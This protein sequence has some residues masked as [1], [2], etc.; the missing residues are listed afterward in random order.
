MWSIADCHLLANSPEDL[1]FSWGEEHPVSTLSALLSSLHWWRTAS[2][3]STQLFQELSR[4]KKWKCNRTS[5]QEKGRH[6]TTRESLSSSRSR[7]C[8]YFSSFQWSTYVQNVKFKS[9][10]IWM[11]F[12][13]N[14][15]MNLIRDFLVWGNVRICMAEPWNTGNFNICPLFFFS[16]PNIMVS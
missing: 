10:L 7:I 4:K 3:H 16:S 15:A 12:I 11:N 13:W 1:G 6:V 2:A 5:Q 8:D 9:T 14:K